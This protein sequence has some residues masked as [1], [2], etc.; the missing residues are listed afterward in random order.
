M[1][2]ELYFGPGIAYV[3]TTGRSLYLPTFQ[4]INI[5][6]PVEVGLLTQQRT[7]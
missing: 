2:F 3:V 6:N 7:L 4:L 5:S 1:S